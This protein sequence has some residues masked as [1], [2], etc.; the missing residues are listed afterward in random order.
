MSCAT[1]EPPFALLRVAQSL[2]ADGVTA[3]VT[4]AFRRAGIESIL[5][6]WPALARW[7]Y[8][9]SS[10]RVYLDA[11]LLVDNARLHEAEAVLARLGFSRYPEVPSPNGEL[12]HAESWVRER[13]A[14]EVDLHRT[15]FGVGVSP[16]A[17]WRE[18]RRATERLDV[19]GVEVDVPS[20]PARGYIVAAHAG[21]HAPDGEKPIEDLRHAVAALSIEDWERTAEL[22]ARLH[23]TQTLAI[24]LSLVPEGAALTERL[25]LADPEVVRST[26][27]PGSSAPLAMGIDRLFRTRGL[28]SKLALL[29][30]EAVPDPGY[31]RWRSPLA[32][33][34]TAGLI[35]AYLLRPL[36][37]AR[38]AIPSVRA[39]RRARR[40]TPP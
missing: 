31:L 27:A 25:G 6:K 16:Q 32:R 18:L 38:Y 30:R 26:V 7:L 4:K 13:D 12:P 40:T 8:E 2:G 37:L 17:V 11:D 1:G 33:R 14:G 22:A 15:L 24:G 39:W 29:A 9:D 20:L 34:G 28:A 23:A 10:S 3:E 19:A 5:L 21:Q 36:W 35:V